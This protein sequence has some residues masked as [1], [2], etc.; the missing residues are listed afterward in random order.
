MKFRQYLILVC[1]A[2]AAFSHSSAAPLSAPAKDC[3]DLKGAWREERPEVGAFLFDTD[4]IV[5]SEKNHT[6]VLSILR[7]EPCQIQV[8]D[9]GLPQTWEVSVEKD[10]LHVRRENKDLWLRRAP[11][12]PPELD[13]KTFPLGEPRSLESSRI[14]T[15]QQELS[16]RRDRDQAVRKDASQKERQAAVDSDNIQF[17]RS[18]VQDVG[19][20]DVERFGPGASS[21]A[22]LLLKHSSDISLTQAV[23]PLVEKDA[24][25][26]TISGEMYS[27]LLDDLSLSLGKKQLYGTQLWQDDKGPFVLPLADPA[28]V[29]ELRKQI[30]LPPL[31]EYLKTASQ[32]IYDGKPIRILAEP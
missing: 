6:R 8:R 14:R 20:I 2:L 11:G 4:R 12:L 31:S 16:T 13:L 3:G 30:G 29:D 22:I 24:K 25:A 26:G 7:A 9:Q 5:V 10:V 1:A 27:I 32:Y 19:W 15:I 17:L 28:R 21:A 23:L 18:L